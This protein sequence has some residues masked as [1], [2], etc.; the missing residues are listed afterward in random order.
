MHERLDERVERAST[1]IKIDPKLWKE[2]KKVAID[3]DIT[4]SELIEQA[5]REW[6]ERRRE[7]K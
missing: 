4:L 3:A 6:M 5:I 2:A 1:S 7:K